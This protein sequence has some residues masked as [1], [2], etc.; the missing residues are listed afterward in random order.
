[1]RALCF[2][3]ISQLSEHITDYLKPHTETL[4]NMI[5]SG[6]GDPVPEVA[7]A[8]LGA[9][10]VYMSSI[11]DEDCVMIMKCTISPMLEV[12]QRCIS[13]GDEEVVFD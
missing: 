7:I 1:M 12:M 3:L 10:A 13:T 2:N 5:C 6:F 4:A 11:A 9:S 8:A